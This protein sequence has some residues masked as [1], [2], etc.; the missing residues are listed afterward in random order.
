[1]N[2]KR[3]DWYCSTERKQKPRLK[4][5]NLFTSQE[6]IQSLS[7]NYIDIISIAGSLYS[8]DYTIDYR[9][10]LRCSDFLL[11]FSCFLK[12]HENVMSFLCPQ[13][14]YCIHEMEEISNIE[15]K[16]STGSC[17]LNIIFICIVSAL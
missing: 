4:L 10:S 14:S 8:I 13:K 6:F 1:M 7:S 11:H 5:I 12:S 3:A 16:R 17:K 9:P 15:I 2:L